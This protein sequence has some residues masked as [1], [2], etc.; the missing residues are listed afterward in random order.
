MNISKIKQR[1]KCNFEFEKKEYD[2][3]FDC[4]F[5]YYG[6]LK[7]T[8]VKSFCETYNHHKPHFQKK[9]YEPKINFQELP[10]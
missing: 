7:P 1:A 5:P 2:N 6:E 10:F 9:T 4:Y 3:L 8:R